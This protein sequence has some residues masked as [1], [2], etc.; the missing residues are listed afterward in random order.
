MPRG[1]HL[2]NYQI[3]EELERNFNQRMK[4]K[5]RDIWAN[6][7]F[8]KGAVF[9]AIGIPQHYFTAMFAMARSAGWLAH[10]LESRQDN[11]LIRPKALYVGSDARS[12][13]GSSAPISSPMN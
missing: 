6:V 8:Y 2:D 4:K 13:G 10:F 7:E 9:E 12:L 3:L 5:G 1:I 11:K